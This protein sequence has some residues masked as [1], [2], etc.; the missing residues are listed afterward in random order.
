MSVLDSSELERA[1]AAS[2]RI[3]VVPM[4]AF[5]PALKL[6]VDPIADGTEYTYIRRSD[7]VSTPNTSP[8][9]DE[10]TMSKLLGLVRN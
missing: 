3:D 4:R 8:P 10:K 5:E 7:P 6:D 9:A 2:A 1:P